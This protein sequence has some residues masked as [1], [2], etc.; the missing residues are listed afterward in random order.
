MHC[1]VHR[2][3]PT[4]ARST[5]NE[6]ARHGSDGAM[7]AERASKRPSLALDPAILWGSV[8]SWT[9]EVPASVAFVN[10]KTPTAFGV[11]RAASMGSFFLMGQRITEMYSVFDRHA[12]VS[13]AT[14]LSRHAQTMRVASLRGTTSAPIPFELCNL[15][16]LHAASAA[17]LIVK[18]VY[19]DDLRNPFF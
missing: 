3:I 4:S 9:H 18:N 11:V 5:E 8:K 15:R 1:L 2:H 19:A 6:A 10:D 7:L 13:D 16:L 17:D 12:P 14:K